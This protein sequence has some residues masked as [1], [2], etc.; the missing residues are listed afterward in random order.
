MAEMLLK[1]P[2]SVGTV[3]NR[4]TATDQ[5]VIERICRSVDG[6]MGYYDGCEEEFWGCE[7]REGGDSQQREVLGQQRTEVRRVTKEQIMC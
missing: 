3:G 6:S 2:T 5:E 1:Y 4:W 7:E